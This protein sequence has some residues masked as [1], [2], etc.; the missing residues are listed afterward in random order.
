MGPRHRLLPSPAMIVAGVALI[1]AL[2]GT[3]AALQRLS[4][5]SLR[6][7]AAR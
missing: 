6:R 7:L 3:A 4:L 2:G 5:E 1:T